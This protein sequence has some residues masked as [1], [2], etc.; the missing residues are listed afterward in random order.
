MARLLSYASGF[1]RL[2]NG[3]AGGARPGCRPARHRSIA[4]HPASGRAHR[5]NSRRCTGS[6]RARSIRAAQ[7]APAGQGGTCASFPN[8]AEERPAVIALAPHR[9]RRYARRTSA[10]ECSSVGRASVSKTEG[11]G[12]ESPHSCHSRHLGNGPGQDQPTRLRPDPRTAICP[13]IRKRGWIAPAPMRTGR[14]SHVRFGRE[15]G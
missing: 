2:L 3:S 11:R 15:E 5:C 7:A 10:E 1:H 13:P 4:R 9:A 6:S 12:F 14:R 8:L